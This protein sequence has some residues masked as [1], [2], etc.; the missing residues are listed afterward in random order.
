MIAVDAMGGDHAPSVVV[1]GAVAAARKGI[2]ILLCGTQSALLSSLPMDWQSLPI[3]V[4]YSTQEIGMD[5]EPVRSIRTKQNSSLVVAMK[6]TA[7]GRATAFFSAGNS[8][9]VLI[10]SVAYVGRVSGVHRPAIGTYLPSQSGSIF[11]LDMG[12]NVDCKAAFLHQF[13]MMGHAYVELT[14]GIK[15][16]RIGLLSNG[17][18]PYKGPQEVK[19]AFELLQKSSLNFIGNIESR[20]ITLG[21]ADVIVCDGFVGNVM[22]KAIQGTAQA[23]FLWIK[24]EAEKSWFQKFCLWLNRSLFYSIRKKTDY[25]SI[26]GALLLGVNNP[27][28]LAHGRSDAR[29]IENGIIFAHRVVVED[30]VKNFNDRLR[31]LLD[32]NKT[33]TGAVSQKVRSLFH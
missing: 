9:A 2:P 22:L 18:E 15:D 12:A 21:T 10:A 28:I 7:S 33:F 8:G 6:A 27:V 25:A 3:T 26:G 19:T 14:K 16:P 11:C 24:Q 5:E 29:A 13:A 30:R 23:L 17:H 20:D 1:Q 32:N 4:E 31:V